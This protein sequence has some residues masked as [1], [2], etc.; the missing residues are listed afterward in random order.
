MVYEEK[1]VV[2]NDI[3]PLQAVG[4]E[5]INILYNHV[6]EWCLILIFDTLIVVLTFFF[7]V[8]CIQQTYMLYINILYIY[9][10]ICMHITYAQVDQY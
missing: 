9:I 10:Y 8:L 4:W 3:P 2:S 6:I 1:Y 7:C 5:G